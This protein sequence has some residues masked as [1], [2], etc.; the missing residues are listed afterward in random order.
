MIL[1]LMLL[2]FLSYLLTMFHQKCILLFKLSI[3]SHHVQGNKMRT[4]Y[5]SLKEITPTTKEWKI[6]VV[7]AEKTMPRARI[8]SPNSKYQKSY[9][10]WYKG[11]KIWKG[12]YKYFLIFINKLTSLEMNIINKQCTLHL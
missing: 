1:L 9:I 2:F 4:P 10:S 11:K 12:K 8:S 7:V 5:H 6:K 3:F